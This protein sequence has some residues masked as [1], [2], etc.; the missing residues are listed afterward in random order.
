MAERESFPPDYYCPNP[1]LDCPGNGSDLIE[2]CEP[3]QDEDGTVLG[4]LVFMACRKCGYRWENE[5]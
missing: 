1:D 4:T 2:V 5:S 3:I